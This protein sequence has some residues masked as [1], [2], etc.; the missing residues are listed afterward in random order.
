[1]RLSGPRPWNPATTATCPSPKRRASFSGVDR[2]DP[3]LA[4]DAVGADRHLP[5]EPRARVDAELLQAPAP[6]APRSPAR[7]RRRRRRIRARRGGARSRCVHC[8]S[9]LVTPAIAETTTA[10][11]LPASTSRLTRRAAFLIRSTVATD[12]PPNFCTMRA[13][14]RNRSRIRGAAAVH[15]R[16]AARYSYSA[17]Q[18][19]RQAMDQSGQQDGGT[20]DRG[21]IERFARAAPRWWDEEGEF[22][23]LHRLN[24][25]RLRFI[26]D[27]LIGHFAREVAR[28]R[29]VRGIAP[30]RYR[31]RRRPGRRADGAAWV[32][33]HRDRR[34]RDRARRRARP[35]RGVRTSRSTIA[36]RR[37]RISP[38]QGQSFDAV[39][40]L[41][42]V[43]H[44]SDAAAVPRDR[45]RGSSR[46]AARLLLRR[47]IAPRDHSSRHRRRRI[48]AALGAARHAS[49]GQVPAA[50]GSRGWH[51]APA[52]SRSG[53][54]QGLVYEPLARRVG[55]S[56]PMSG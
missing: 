52:V 31:L 28:A 15:C 5:A 50:V 2:R 3:R 22:R 35:C 7:P 23:P 51:C 36:R 13:M 25:V 47:S 49:L 17:R 55:R 46:R 33:R 44:A 37:P 30:A 8:T 29:A 11:S 34:R 42:V 45:R 16:Q 41:E 10:T 27:R 20:I 39:L 24:P 21:E 26:R 1:M 19:P 48:R 32:C 43:E 4:V 38:P 54:P 53:R 6:S 56:R 18:Q 14:A 40:A 9:W 12:V